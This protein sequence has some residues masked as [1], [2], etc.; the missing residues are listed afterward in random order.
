VASVASVLGVGL[1]KTG[2]GFFLSDLYEGEYDEIEEEDDGNQIKES[3]GHKR[4]RRKG[5]NAFELVARG[6]KSADELVEGWQRVKDQ[7]R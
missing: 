2:K 7:L 3:D 1:G 5:L 6:F 4:R